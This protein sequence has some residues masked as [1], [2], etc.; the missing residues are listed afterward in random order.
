MHQ[1]WNRL[2][3]LGSLRQASLVGMAGLSILFATAGCGDNYRPVVQAINPVGP[4]GQLT[5]YAVAVSIPPI[6]NAPSLA[7]IVDFSGDTVLATPN[8]VTDPNYLQVDV[9]GANGYVIDPDG[10]LDEFALSNPSTFLTSDVVATSL[11]VES[12]PVSISAFA[13]AS[14]L[15][16]VFI[17]QAGL[18]SIA[19]VNASTAALY[20]SVGIEAGGSNPVYVVGAKGTPRVYAISQNAPGTNGQVDSI[21]TV[22]TTTLSDSAQIPVGIAPIYG[23]MTTNTYR[24]FILN[25]GSGT[26]SVINVP[27]NELD[28]D[29]PTITVGTNPVW[30]DVNTTGD[31]VVVLNAGNAPHLDNATGMSISQYYMGS[32]SA[33]ATYQ[34]NQIVTYTVGSQTSYYMAL[35]SGLKGTPPTNTASWKQLT[36]GSLSI[37]NV[38]LCNAAAQPNN[39]NCVP[40]NPEDGVGFG[41]VVATV[42][43]G[44]GANMVSVLQ[45][46]EGNPPAAYVTNELDSTGTCG[47]GQ[48]SVT[49]IS[50]ESDTVTTTICGVSGSAATLLANGQ[51]NVIF[52]HPNSVAATGG[53][54]TGRVY[55]TS[56]DNQ[57]LSVI[58]TD[59]NQVST[60][61]PLQG[62]GLM[63]EVTAP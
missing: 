4:A 23:V 61:I 45:G 41:N 46:I 27:S 62:N 2:C 57:Y 39:P 24:A 40:T 8:L 53:L 33:T 63:V 13:P 60:H 48:G 35:N 52:G 7:T 21:E 50:L 29:K 43:V 25:Q 47:L 12:D 42:P 32:Y 16:T 37:I 20:D 30:A 18:N 11:P 6:A 36:A 58:H 31:E 9:N 59:T 56:S 17:P 10:S 1:P 5:K 34:Q 49:V 26:V 51:S 15:D 55:V 38:P 54:P 28:V 3:R 22:S 14:G 44:I 19:A